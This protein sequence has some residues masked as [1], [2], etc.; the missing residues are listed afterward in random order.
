LIAA[1]L[2][3]AL[4]AGSLLAVANQR[5]P[6]VSF[7]FVLGSWL[8]AW[9]LVELAFHVLVGGALIVGLLAALGALEH[10]VGWIGLAL[11][12]LAAAAIA[13][14]AWGSRRTVVSV[15]GRPEDLEITS[16]DA[17]R[18]PWI[19][20][21]IPVLAPW[22]RGVRHERGLVYAQVDRLRL[23]LDVYRSTGGPEAPRPAVLHV[24]GGGWVIGSR[25]EQGLPLLNHL[26]ANGW[27]GF[28]IDYRLSPRAT[29]P[30]HVIDVKRAI[31]WVRENA[32]R[33]G[34]DPEFIAL[35]GGSAGG[36]LTALAAL[37]ADDKSL[38]PGFE[39]A[40]TS[41]QAAVPFYGVYD[42]L[43]AARH[44]LRVTHDVLEW[45]VVKARADREPERYRA[46]SPLY[47]IHPDAPPFFVVHGTGD[48]L[49]PVAESRQFV[50][51]L[52]TVSKEPVLYAEMLGAQHA[53]DLI[54]SWRTVRVIEA[55]ERFLAI[56]Y[57][58]RGAAGAKVEAELAGEM[59]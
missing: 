32:D 9:L 41:V 17:P 21:L 46:I 45:V 10:V 18:V 50:R 13:G 58:N 56:G 52:R 51:R 55:I 44:Q 29:L 24:H 35:T 31:A 1:W 47:R 25:F 3:L 59:A 27:V 28:N 6:R 42:M 38:Q 14:H 15:E 33:L 54:P 4:G 30:D 8:A 12:V 53:F 43:D 5:R 40:D 19:Y 7:F 23:R 34:V 26:A 49:V 57:E 36:H 37:T 48:T 20:P 11:W 2:L 39:D 16:L 22:R